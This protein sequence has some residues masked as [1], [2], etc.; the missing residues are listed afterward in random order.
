MYRKFEGDISKS[1]AKGLDAISEDKK[2]KF[3]AKNKEIKSL[4]KEGILG[5]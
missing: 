5:G 1:F 3:S 4:I 2:P